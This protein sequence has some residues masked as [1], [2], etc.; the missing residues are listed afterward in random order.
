LDKLLQH[1]EKILM[2][3]LNSIISN[4]VIKGIIIQQENNEQKWK[5]TSSMCPKEAVKNLL[6]T[7]LNTNAIQPQYNWKCKRP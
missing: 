6:P 3:D 1:Y 4:K 7:N 5:A 2:N